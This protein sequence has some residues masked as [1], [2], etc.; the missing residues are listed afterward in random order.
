MALSSNHTFSR[1]VLLLLM[2]AVFPAASS[3]SHTLA[4]GLDDYKR[5]SLEELMDLDVTSAAKQSEPYWQASAAL[6]VVTGDA[7]RRSGATHLPEALR[8]ADSLHV[9]QKSSHGWAISARG[10]RFRRR[11][12]AE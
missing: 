7:I 11:S 10:F 2:S 12:I 1:S 6:Q 8:L 4:L 3:Y 9:A 5:M